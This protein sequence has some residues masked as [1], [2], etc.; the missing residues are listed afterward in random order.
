M[1]LGAWGDEN[2]HDADYDTWADRARDAGWVDPD[3][4][5]PGAIDILKE[6]DRQES[7]EGW[8]PEHDDAH[9]DETLALVAALYTTPMQLYCVEKGEDFFTFEDPWPVGWDEIH[10]R[11]GDFDRRRLLVIAGALIAA[12]IDRLD[13]AKERQRAKGEQEN[14][15]DIL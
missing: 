5:S 12:E 6:R 7:E 14:G 9:I 11:R 15:Q 13:R 2:P 8:T 1:S 3:D 4:Y 10:D